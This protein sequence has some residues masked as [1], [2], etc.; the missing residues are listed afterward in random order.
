MRSTHVTL[1]MVGLVALVA[2]CQG[3]QHEEPPIHI[4]PNMDYQ[5]YYE[6]QEASEYYEDG[7]AARPP[8]EG[9]VARGF[10]KD[11]THL[12]EGRGPDGRLVEK[13]P[14]TIKLDQSLL[15]RGQER[16]DIY[17]S[18]CHDKAGT[19]HGVVTARG[20]G[21]QVQP[22][23]MHQDR[24]RAMPLGHFYDVITNG[25]GTMYPYAAQISVED[26]W[27]IAVWV[28]TLQKHGKAKGWD[29]KTNA[30][31]MAAA[32]APPAK[33]DPKKPEAQ[34]E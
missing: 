8:V 33:A 24:L 18:P 6:A 25:K 12:W 4:I 7:R 30:R 20:G 2:G 13:L 23:S 22:A 1:A 5:Q 17:C 14:G 11:N 10:L 34:D 21:F 26:R 32:E 15:E 9:T 19:G 27:A 3:Q 31:Q 29:E 28:R 16:Y